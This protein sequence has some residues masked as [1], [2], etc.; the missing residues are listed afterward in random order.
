MNKIHILMI[1]VIVTGCKTFDETHACY[2]VDGATKRDVVSLAA[3]LAI[4][5]DD[6]VAIDTIVPEP[7]CLGRLMYNGDE[8]WYAPEP[9]QTGIVP[10]KGAYSIVPTSITVLNEMGQIYSFA[11]QEGVTAGKR[12]VG[13]WTAAIPIENGAFKYT[14]GGGVD[15]TVCPSDGFAISGSFTSPTSAQ[16]VIYY[17]CYCVVQKV[18]HFIATLVPEVDAGK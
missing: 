18:E 11:V 7:D 10:N 13:F 12:Y 5:P 6:A 14:H 3:D 16:G 8:C 15:G 9:T 1:S 4:V 17:S 2:E